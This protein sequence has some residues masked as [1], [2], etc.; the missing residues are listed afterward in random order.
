L[1]EIELTQRENQKLNYKQF[2]A[3]YAKTGKDR[4]N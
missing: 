4:E 3:L 1:I 2:V